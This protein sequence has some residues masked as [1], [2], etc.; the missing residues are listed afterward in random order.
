VSDYPDIA[1]LYLVT[2][3]LV[4]DYSSSMFDFAVTG[5]PILFYTYDL[6][7]YRDHVRGFYFDFAE[8]APGPLL[9]TSDEVIDA[10]RDLDAVAR[11]SAPAYRAFRRRFCP[12]DDGQAA[13]RVLARVLPDRKEVEIPA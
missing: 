12:S 9:G 1:E 11:R 5:K 3:V 10:L 2:D 8:V 4:T 7:R 13:A 6:E